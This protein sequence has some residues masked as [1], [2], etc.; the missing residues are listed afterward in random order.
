MRQ[1]LVVLKSDLGCNQDSDTEPI[2]AGQEASGPVEQQECDTR[3]ELE[4][5]LCKDH[6]L[7]KATKNEE[8][9]ETRDLSLKK[10]NKCGS[11]SRSKRSRETRGKEDF[12]EDSTEMMGAG[13]ESDFRG[14]VFEEHLDA[15]PPREAASN[16]FVC[17][18]DFEVS[19]ELDELDENFAG[20]LHIS[21]R[22]S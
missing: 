17:D 19:K 14:V 22:Y 1:M 2:H 21:P 13:K 7:R 4:L 5:S 16:L 11:L 18:N 20:A 6:R 10:Q 3:E 15:S 9:L 8:F 12:S